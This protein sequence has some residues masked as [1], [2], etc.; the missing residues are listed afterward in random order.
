MRIEPCTKQ[1]MEH[2]K[3]KHGGVRA[4]RTTTRGHLVNESNKLPNKGRGLLR[5][6]LW[7]DVRADRNLTR[8]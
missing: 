7:Q 6:C 3:L 2:M 5:G 8:R 1:P 4:N